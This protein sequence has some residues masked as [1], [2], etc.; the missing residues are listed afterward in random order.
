MDDGACAIGECGLDYHYDHSPRERSVAA[1]DAQIDL[2]RPTAQLPLV[3]HTREAEA[4]HAS[5]SRP[6]GGIARRARRA[7]LLH[8]LAAR[9]REAALEAGWYVSFSGIVTFKK[10]SDDDVDP[11]RFPKTACSSSPTRRISRRS[12]IAEIATSR[13]GSRT[14][15]PRGGR[16]SARGVRRES[17]A[18]RSRATP[19]GYFLLQ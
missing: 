18:P 3:V 6:R 4:R 17:S 11:A 14:R 9:S 13:R 16:R 5:R 2:A 15:S 1:F 12:R 8:R 19:T 10:W 7:A